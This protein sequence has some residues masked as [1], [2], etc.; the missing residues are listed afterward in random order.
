MTEQEKTL[1]KQYHDYLEKADKLKEKA[2]SAK[3]ELSKLAPHKVGEI[4]R[5]TQTGRTKNI[6]S[7][8]LRQHEPLPDKDMAAVCT[9]VNVTI[10]KETFFYDYVFSPLKKDGSIS[11][12]RC[13]P[14]STFVWTGEYH[15][16][17]KKE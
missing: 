1:V 9:A 5:W 13:Y 4:I 10:W 11:N 8:W 16:N 14:Q 17:Y 7:G 3:L 15:E 12:N 2:E 6:G